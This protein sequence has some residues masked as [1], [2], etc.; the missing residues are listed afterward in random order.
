MEQ[1]LN[2]LNDVDPFRLN[3]FSDAV[4]WVQILN[5]DLVDADMTQS[6]EHGIDLMTAGQ[7]Y[8]ETYVGG[9]G[10]VRNIQKKQKAGTA[11]THRQLRAALNVMRREVSALPRSSAN[12]EG[13][14]D[15]IPCYNCTDTFDTWDDLMAH[16]SEVHGPGW[17]ERQREQEALDKERAAA[18]LPFNGE[19]ED[20]IRDTVA[21]M[22]IDLTNLPDG[23]YAYPNLSGTTKDPFIYLRVARTNKTKIRDRRYRYGERV[24]GNEVVLAGTIEVRRYIS[25]TQELVGQQKPG[26]LYRGENEAELNGILLDPETFGLLFGI[27]MGH[28]TIC[29]KKLTDELSQ[30]LGMGL[31]CEKKD[32]Y[33]K[34]PSKWIKHFE[35][36]C[37]C[38]AKLEQEV[39]GYHR[40]GG[41]PKFDGFD[42]QNKHTYYEC[43]SGHKWYVPEKGDP[44]VT[45]ST[46]K[47]AVAS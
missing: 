26:D 24:V 16:K 36:S 5:R 3:T 41:R 37:P 32:G 33:F 11:L 39:E 18:D 6:A 13:T 15:K 20:V 42:Y 45:N 7:V 31:E 9:D 2:D 14:A 28:C 44:V 19:E 27:Q 46:P 47:A 43:P 12:T 8:V 29:G 22:G 35:A 1:Q 4:D 40:P 21:H 30:A 23:R 10:F 17:R 25:D 34:N 38:C